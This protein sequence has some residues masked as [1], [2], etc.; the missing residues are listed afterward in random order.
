MV[1]IKLFGDYYIRSDTMNVMLIQSVNGRDKILGYYS[2]LPGAI[3][4]FLQL[5][6]RLS[7]ATSITSLLL[8]LKSLEQALTKALHPLKLKVGVKE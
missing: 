3:E 7:N 6:L 5:K 4:A 2:T 1:N 8:E